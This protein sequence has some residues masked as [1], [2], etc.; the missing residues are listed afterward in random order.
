MDF[1]TELAQANLPSEAKSEI[2]ELIRAYKASFVLTQQTLSDQVDDLGQIYNRLR[3]ALGEIM[4]AADAHSQ[5]AE[6]PA[7]EIRRKLVWV[8]GLAILLT[9]LL[10]LLFGQRI[11]KTVA[12]M[13]SAMRQLGEGASMWFYQASAEETSL[14]TWLKR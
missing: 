4:A 10:A 6:M 11:A 5:A 14:T 9:G 13:A 2:L 7:E 12:S 1:E 3:P 8:I